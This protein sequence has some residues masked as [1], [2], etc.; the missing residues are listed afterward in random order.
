MS[1]RHQTNRRKAY[2]RRQHEVRERHDRRHHLD[3]DQEPES[4]GSTGH[5]DPL[6]GSNLRPEL[7]RVADST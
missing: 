7:E 5:A 3:L 4:W 1:R 2:G 6:T